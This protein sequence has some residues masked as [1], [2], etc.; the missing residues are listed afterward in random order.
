MEANQ[1]ERQLIEF[2]TAT[3]ARG[4]VTQ[5]E[6][7]LRSGV[8]RVAVS[9]ILGGRQRASTVMWNRLLTAA[10]RPEE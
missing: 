10:S 5:T 2:V 6:L 1:V 9:R 3:M 4:G 8:A 7:A